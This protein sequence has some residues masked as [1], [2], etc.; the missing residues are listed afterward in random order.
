[1]QIWCRSSDEIRKAVYNLDG[2]GK[3][4]RQVSLEF[5]ER[6]DDQGQMFVAVCPWLV[7]EMEWMSSQSLTG[8]WRSNS[9]R[10]VLFYP[11]AR[12]TTHITPFEGIAGQPGP[13]AENRERG[14]R[15]RDGLQPSRA[16][17]CQTRKTFTRVRKLS[18]PWRSPGALTRRRGPIKTKCPGVR[19]SDGPAN[20]K[21]EPPSSGLAVAP[22]IGPSA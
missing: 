17:P 13:R 1:M 10:S 11:R 7:D 22:S 5:A 14:Q 15:R 3:L 2:M 20:Q 9:D 8:G 21:C 6:P 12:S 4:R 16:Q 18:W 19:R